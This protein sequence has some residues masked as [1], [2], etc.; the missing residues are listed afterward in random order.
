MTKPI[1]REFMDDWWDLTRRMMDHEWFPEGYAESLRSWDQFSLWWLV[2]KEE[3][4]KD[5]KV[6]I[7]D[8]DLRWNYYNALNWAISRP[9]KPVVVRHYSCGL[10]KDGYIL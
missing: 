10:D 9:E 1:V 5:L 7:F 2:E 4:Y 3:K 8:D 6:G